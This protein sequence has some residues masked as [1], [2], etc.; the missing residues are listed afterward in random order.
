[1]ALGRRLQ[2]LTGCWFEASVP[3]HI[4]LSIGLLTTWKLASWSKWSERACEQLRQPDCFH[5][6]ISWALYHHFCPILLLI[7]TTL[8]PCGMALHRSKNTSRQG[9]LGAILE[10][11][12]KDLWSSSQLFSRVSDP[13]R[14]PS[15][16]LILKRVERYRAEKACSM[17]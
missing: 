4:G 14:L 13:I 17:F 15:K 12:I 1:M 7:Q 6:L 16:A 11:D 5:K 8:V 3:C 2:F 10:A 9:S